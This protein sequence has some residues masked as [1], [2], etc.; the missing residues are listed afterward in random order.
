MKIKFDKPKTGQSFFTLLLAHAH[1]VPMNV[2]PRSW[3]K[4]LNP[5]GR[6]VS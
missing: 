3:W 6:D 5:D 2:T 1:H 4:K